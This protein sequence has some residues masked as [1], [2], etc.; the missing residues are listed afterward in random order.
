[1]EKREN[2]SEPK[3][4]ITKEETLLSIARML[5][6]EEACERIKA[7]IEKGEEGIKKQ[8]KIFCL[9]LTIMSA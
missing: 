7:Q 5:L 3:E 6:D 9:S 2:L 8:R 1:M 4:K